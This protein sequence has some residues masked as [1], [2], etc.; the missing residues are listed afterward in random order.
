MLDLILTTVLQSGG[1]RSLRPSLDEHLA[2][3]TA[4]SKR[5]DDPS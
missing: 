5:L 2:L 3:V 4:I 1:Y